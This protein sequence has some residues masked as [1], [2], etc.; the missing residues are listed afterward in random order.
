MWN[1]F[2][3]RRG[4]GDSIRNPFQARERAPAA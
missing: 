1:N 4:R 2:P 3:E